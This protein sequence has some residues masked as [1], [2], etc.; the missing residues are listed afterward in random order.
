MQ[1]DT[2]IQHVSCGGLADGSLT[3]TVLSGGV[4][5]YNHSWSNGQIDLNSASS[6]INGLIAG[7]YSDTIT[8]GNGCDTIISFTITEPLTIITTTNP[9]NISCNGLCDGTAATN[10]S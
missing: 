5:P 2:T 9:T 7:I 6:T 1:I 8:D 10:T 3:A 4:A